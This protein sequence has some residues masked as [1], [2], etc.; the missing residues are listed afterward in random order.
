M[1]LSLVESSPDC[2]EK[3]EPFGSLVV[4]QAAH[5]QYLETHALRAVTQAQSFV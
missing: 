5:L 2:Q 4:R 3:N 1:A